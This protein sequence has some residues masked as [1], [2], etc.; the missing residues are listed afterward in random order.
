MVQISDQK[1]MSYLDY[2][3][4]DAVYIHFPKLLLRFCASRSTHMK[5]CIFHLHEINCQYDSAALSS[6]F[7][8]SAIRHMDFFAFKHLLCTSSRAIL[9]DRG[10]TF[11]PTFCIQ[12]L[13]LF[14]VWGL[15][16]PEASASLFY[17]MNL[18]ILWSLK[19]NIV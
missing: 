18:S 11:L 12:V 16:F 9:Y 1:R 15:R 19:D 8:R 13:S 14:P 10:V 7:A 3:M 6:D 4:T 2:E 5:K 17:L